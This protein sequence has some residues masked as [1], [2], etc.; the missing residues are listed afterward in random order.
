MFTGKPGGGGVEGEREKLS[1]F[2]FSL[3]A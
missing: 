3:M 1:T 2:L